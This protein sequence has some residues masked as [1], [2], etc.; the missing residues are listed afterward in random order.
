MLL[1]VCLVTI[2]SGGRDM[3]AFL[4]SST[5]AAG[6]REDGVVLALDNVEIIEDLDDSSEVLWC[7]RAGLRAERRGGSSGLVRRGDLV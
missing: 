4:S 7:R 1:D 5:V 6:N 3:A 2:E